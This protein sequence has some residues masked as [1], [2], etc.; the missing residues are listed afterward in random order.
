MIFTAFSVIVFNPK[1]NVPIPASAAME[2]ESALPS[3]PERTVAAFDV[4]A[5]LSPH[6]TVSPVDTGR[7]TTQPADAIGYS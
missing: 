2:D 3:S 4:E 7:T 6:V 1:I 5:H